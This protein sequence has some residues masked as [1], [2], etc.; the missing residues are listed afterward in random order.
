MVSGGCIP[1]Q[2]WVL[3]PTKET[4][5]PARA[6]HPLS[7]PTRI[8]QEGCSI[9]ETETEVLVASIGNGYQGRRM[10][11]ASR[12][13]ARGIKVC[14]GPRIVASLGMRFAIGSGKAPC[15]CVPAM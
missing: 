9:R 8:A 13:W 3:L 12:L 14:R 5:T 10:G 1:A 2:L 4:G 7:N 15:I 11:I 6:Q